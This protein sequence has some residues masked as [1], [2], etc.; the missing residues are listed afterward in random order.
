MIIELIE[1]EVGFCQNTSKKIPNIFFHRFEGDPEN[2]YK[3]IGMRTSLGLKKNCTFRMWRLITRF[4]LMN[5]LMMLAY[6]S[7]SISRTTNAEVVKNLVIL[8]NAI[9]DLWNT[10]TI[11]A[12]T[13]WQ[14]LLWQDDL[15]HLNKPVIESYR[16]QSAFMKDSILPRF[17]AAQNQDLGSYTQAYKAFFGQKSMCELLDK[18]NRHV[19]I[20]CGHGSAN[21]LGQNFLISLYASISVLDEIIDRAEAA[22]GNKTQ[23]RALISDQKFKAY[24]SLFYS[25]NA[26][27]DIYYMMG[28]PLLEAMQEY[29]SP[30]R[31]LPNGEKEHIKKNRDQS[32]FMKLF[33]PLLLAY[34]ILCFI[35]FIQVYVEE[36]RYYWGTLQLI[37]LLLIRKNPVLYYAFMKAF[38]GSHKLVQF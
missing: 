29:L 30:V 35:I 26:L 24:I 6:Y 32:V 18:Y 21:M 31:L 38:R 36:M 19:F 3:N 23:I 33:S 22:K 14:Y 16:D 28:L 34:L 15:K 12:G 5:A 10:Q 27:G 37:P 9:I 11:M 7:W 25:S 13:V 1:D 4:L 17:K 8:N 20:G 2:D